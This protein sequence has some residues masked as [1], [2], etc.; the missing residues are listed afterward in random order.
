MG[1]FDRQDT[2]SD[3]LT[4]TLGNATEEL[5]STF[6]RQIGEIVNA[7]KERAAEIELEA[8][9][10]AEKIE[11]DAARK[12][13][14][15]ELEAQRREAAIEDR[16]TT[17][18]TRLLERVNTLGDSIFGMLDD[19]RIELQNAL[20]ERGAA[21]APEAPRAETT[22]TPEAGQ[23]SLDLTSPESIPGEPIATEPPAPS[24][25]QVNGQPAADSAAPSRL[26]GGEATGQPPPAEPADRP[27]PTD[28]LTQ[29][30]P[31]AD[32]R[33]SLAPELDHMLREQL[34]TM[35]RN[36]KSR[37]EAAQFLMRFNLGK[38]YVGLIDEIYWSTSE[39]DKP[40][41]RQRFA[42]RRRNRQR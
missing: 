20:D 34:T 16:E 13:Q 12:A 24:E 37:A 27:H 30:A 32:I 4:A 15:R 2:G 8:S 5:R 41:S 39:P 31:V 29:P 28:Q 1:R 19:M 33:P 40:V 18:I 14:D 6:E 36:G 7:A 17:Q 21:D 22:P 42:R 9:D 3:P 11:E 38:S 26:D 10:R 23:P 25:Q 35:F